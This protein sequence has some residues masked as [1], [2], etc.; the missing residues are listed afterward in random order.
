[1]KWR[2]TIAVL[3]VLLLA[4][5]LNAQENQSLKT[6]KQK[7]SYIIGMDIGQHFKSQSMDIDQAA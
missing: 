2:C 7:L 5:S 3:G 1:M 6:Q 4:G